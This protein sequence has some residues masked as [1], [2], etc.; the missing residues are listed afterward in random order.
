[1]VSWDVYKIFALLVSVLIFY[2]DSSNDIQAKFFE[3]VLILL[4][5]GLCIFSWFGLVYSSRR[6]RAKI[7]S[8]NKLEFSK[9]PMFSGTDNIGI[10]RL[11]VEASLWNTTNP[12]T[13]MPT[14]ETQTSPY[15]SG[16]QW[17]TN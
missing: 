11:Q 2:A 14:V 5:S 13:M 6:V 9:N 15:T 12:S 17:T 4:F 8:T 1:M 7:T 16:I 10:P 3:V